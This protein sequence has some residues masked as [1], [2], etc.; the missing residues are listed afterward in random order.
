M[1]Q[2]NGIVLRIR[3]DKTDEFERLF[4]DGVARRDLSAAASR[5]QASL[6]AAAS[7]RYRTI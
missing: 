5:R 7:A 4:A 2:A 6:A 3:T 1:A